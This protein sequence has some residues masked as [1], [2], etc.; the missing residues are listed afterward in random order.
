MF[1]LVL[2]TNCDTRSSFTREELM[3]IRGTTPADLFSIVLRLQ[4]NYWTF[5]SNVHSALCNKFDKVQLLWG[6]TRD[7]Y[8]SSILS[9][10]EMFLCYLKPDFKLQLESFQLFR[11]ELCGVIC[12]FIN[13]GW[14]EPQ[15]S[16]PAA[17][18]LWS[19]IILH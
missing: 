6:K 13:S 3:N 19:G 18:F 15:D 2:F 9:F 12:L 17:L 7:F 8:L 16:D 14:C 4:C 5:L 11:V 1:R 10:M